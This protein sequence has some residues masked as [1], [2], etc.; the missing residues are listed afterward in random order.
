MAGAAG[1]VSGA[2]YGYYESAKGAMFL[3][4]RHVALAYDVSS[5][6]LSKNL[7]K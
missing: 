4:D 1:A 6:E 3:K 7:R 2:G 5:I